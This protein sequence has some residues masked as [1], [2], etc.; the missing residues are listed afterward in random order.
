MSLDGHGI[1]AELGEDHAALFLLGHAESAEIDVIRLE[2]VILLALVV[3]AAHAVDE[4]GGI[5]RAHIVGHRHAVELSPALV[6]DAPEDYRGESA[7]IFHR[8]AHELLVIFPLFCVLARERLIALGVV[9]HDAQKRQGADDGEV[10][11]SP[12]RDH[13]LP[14]Q[15]TQPVAMVI[16]ARRL[17][18]DMLADHV[19]AAVLH[20]LNVVYHGAVG[21]GREHALGIIALI[22]QAALE[23]IFPVELDPLEAARVRAKLDF[24]HGEITAH[25]VF[26]ALYPHLVKKGRIG[27]PELDAGQLYHVVARAAVKLGYL[28][29]LVVYPDVHRAEHPA[30]AHVDLRPVGVGEAEHVF[31]IFIGDFFRPDRS[32]DPRLRRIP[33]PAARERLLALGRGRLV[34]EVDNVH[35]ERVFALFAGVGHVKGKGQIAPFVHPLA[36]AV[37][38]H[39]AFFVHRLEMQQYPLPARIFEARAI[40]EHLVEVEDPAHAARVAFGTE[41]HEDLPRLYVRL[42]FQAHIF[43]RGNYP[44]FPITVENSIARALHLRTGIFRTRLFAEGK[45]AVFVA[46]GQLDAPRPFA[47]RLVVARIRRLLAK[48][49][50]IDNFDE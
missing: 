9:E 10:V 11:F 23:D 27:R 37:D 26:A 31:D 14:H 43:A 38:K 17:Y 50:G 35:L 4:T 21:R 49:M 16:P 47:R 13:V 34:R 1:A 22:E 46:R 24:P 20:L 42:S 7:Q 29:A 33:D 48:I 3:P 39:F 40:D 36:H 6:E 32:P 2:V 30:Y 8:F 44:V 45:V 15:H 19:E 18:L 12:A 28:P 5:E 25:A 41:R